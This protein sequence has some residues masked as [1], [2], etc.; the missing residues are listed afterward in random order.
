MITCQGM[1]GGECSGV[2]EEYTCRALRAEAKVAAAIDW[3]REA[4]G[5][6]HWENVMAPG[7][8]RI[9]GVEGPLESH[10]NY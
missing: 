5:D 7:L 3:A 6:W 10:A 1:V 8:L 9:L 4:Y 2:V